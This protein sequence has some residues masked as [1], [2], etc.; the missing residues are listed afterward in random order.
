MEEFFEVFTTGTGTPFRIKV[1][2]IW[3]E[4]NKIYFNIL[5]WSTTYGL[6]T[7]IF[8]HVKEKIYWCNPA[9]INNSIIYKSEIIKD[10]GSTVTDLKESKEVLQDTYDTSITLEDLIKEIRENIKQIKLSIDRLI[11]SGREKLKQKG[12]RAFT[13]YTARYKEEI[14]KV[15]VPGEINDQKVNNLSNSLTRFFTAIKFIEKKSSEFSRYVQS[16]YTELDFLTQ[17]L[18]KNHTILI[19]K[20]Q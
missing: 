19:K 14:Q 11:K 4:N 3:I 6:P 17:K 8:K 1:N 15:L 16:E 18:E 12:I 5:D 9:F 2:K 13:F 20:T 7:K 10:K